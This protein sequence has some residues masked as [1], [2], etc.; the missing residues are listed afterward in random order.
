MHGWGRTRFVGFLSPY[1]N[2]TKDPF[3]YRQRRNE[4]QKY[5]VYVH[6]LVYLRVTL[7]P[8]NRYTIYLVQRVIAVDK[9][10]VEMEAKDITF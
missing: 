7:P 2:R 1:T 9:L 4:P 8:A 10:R 6:P 5:R 3:V